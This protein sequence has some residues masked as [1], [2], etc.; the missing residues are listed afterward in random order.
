MTLCVLGLSAA[1]ARKS[2][3]ISPKSGDLLRYLIFLFTQS[4]PAGALLASSTTSRSLV[5]GSVLIY[6]GCTDAPGRDRLGINVEFLP[7]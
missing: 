6:T 1:E 4:V 5:P 2:S 7:V 3:M